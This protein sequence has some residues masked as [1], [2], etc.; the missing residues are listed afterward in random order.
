[1]F[2]DLH[3]QSHRLNGNFQ[4]SVRLYQVVCMHVQIRVVQYAGRSNSFGCRD[5]TASSGEDYVVTSCDNFFEMSTS[6]AH[7]VV[8]LAVVVLELRIDGVPTAGN[9]VLVAKCLNIEMFSAVTK[10]QVRA[11]GYARSFC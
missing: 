6:C 8:L 3:N 11:E 10:R 4:N 9:L 2:G 7:H 1:M 5:K